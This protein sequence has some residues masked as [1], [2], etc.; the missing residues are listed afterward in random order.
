[1]ANYVFDG[2]NFIGY[3]KKIDKNSNWC[4][5]PSVSAII[6]QLD[7]SSA[8]IPWAQRMTC[9][10]IVENWEECRALEGHRLSNFM[11]DA[12]KNA[13]KKRDEAGQYGT[14]L[15]KI[16]EKALLDEKIKSECD[17]DVEFY[18]AIYSWIKENKICME[19][20]PKSLNIEAPIVNIA[21]GYAGSVDLYDFNTGTLYDLKTSKN[22]HDTHILQLAG[23]WTA[24][25][26]LLNT[27]D[28]DW[29]T[30]SPSEVQKAKI[31]HWDKEN[32]C[33]TEIDIT[34]KVKKQIPAFLC[35]V[36]LYYLLKNRRVKNARTEK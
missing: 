5:Y 3:D 31:L 33:L 24:I 27:K 4:S 8:L 17:D 10:Y 2:V 21:A 1:M 32:L 20:Y 22:V 34:S 26:I 13:L 35:L 25:D 18:L 30:Y 14:D 16:L 19:N 28:S 36:D 7:K 6:G 9:E 15:H 29:C 11:D 23:Y 12:K